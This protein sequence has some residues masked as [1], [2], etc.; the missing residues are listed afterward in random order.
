MLLMLELFRIYCSKTTRVKRNYAFFCKF[1]QNSSVILF[2]F[3]FYNNRKHL[4]KLQQTPDSFSSIRDERCLIYTVRLWMS[5]ASVLGTK[6]HRKLKLFVGKCYILFDQINS[7]I[8][9]VNGYLHVWGKLWR[10][11]EL[12]FAQFRY[13]PKASLYVRCKALRFPPIQL[14]SSF[15]LPLLSIFEFQCSLF[16]SVKLSWVSHRSA[17]FICEC[18]FAFL[19]S[20]SAHAGVAVSRAVLERF[21]K[22]HEWLSVPGQSLQKSRNRGVLYREQLE[23][24]HSIASTPA[25]RYPTAQ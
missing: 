4:S 5:E 13:M 22:T 21:R 9:L 17:D 20:R 23:L 7:C 3:S 15:P 6:S 25:G 11:W 10:T 19:R 24:L 8:S 18:C 12:I 1:W 14:A 2:F 16:G